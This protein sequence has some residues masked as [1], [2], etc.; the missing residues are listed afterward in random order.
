MAN[1]GLE[2]G[3]WSGVCIALLLTGTVEPLPF[4]HKLN[5]FSFCQTF[6]KLFI[7]CAKILINLK[8]CLLSSESQT[9]R[10]NNWNSLAF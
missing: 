5:Y 3:M 2:E 10:D 4:W 8:F 1:A 9:F 7:I 6:E